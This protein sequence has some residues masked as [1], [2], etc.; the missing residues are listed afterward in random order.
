MGVQAFSGPRCLEQRATLAYR[1]TLQQ[2]VLDRPY[3]R[4]VRAED[5]VTDATVYIL[6][7]SKTYSNRRAKAQLE[8]LDPN[9]AFPALEHDNVGAF[10]TI[11][12][13]RGDLLLVY[14]GDAAPLLSDRLVERPGEREYTWLAARALVL[15]VARAIAHAHDRGWVH[16][17][18]CPASIAVA[19]SDPRRPDVV[20]HDVG[21]ASIAETQ[22]DHALLRWRRSSPYCAPELLN[23]AHATTRADVYALGVLLWELA[24]GRPPFRPSKL[25]LFD[26]ERRRATLQGRDCP[27]ELEALLEI[28]L[29]PVPG[30]RFDV[31]ELLETLEVLSDPEDI[32]AQSGEFLSEEL[33]EALNDLDPSELRVVQRHVDALL[34]V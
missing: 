9:A 4:L 31:H 34:K 2:L 24:S 32:C 23:G 26:A 19:P 25:P 15:E 22:R 17:A 11:R 33:L 27:D 8:A 12:D 7:L 16:G 20:V 13:R 21:L 3:G 14:S 6:M 28:A 10:E 1:Y 18:L 30:D 5:A 29:A